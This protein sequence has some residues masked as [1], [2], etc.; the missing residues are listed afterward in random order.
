[1]VTT[2]S[3]A[4][5]TV[6]LQG[7]SDM[8]VDPDHHLRF[9]LNGIPVTETSFDGMKPHS[10]SVD[11][12]ASV[13]LEGAN[14]LSIESLTDTGATQS[15][16]YLDRFSLEYPHALASEAGSLEGQ[17]L[18]DGVV[19]ATGFAPGSV[20]IDLSGRVPRWMGRSRT[21]I[22]F[23]AEQGHSYLAVSPEAFLRPQIRP[24]EVSPLRDT[25]NQ[26]D[27]ILVAPRDFL[28][29][30]QPLVD[31]R[32]AQGLAVMAVALEDIYDSFG[33]GE[34]SPEAIHSF[35]S[36][37]YHHWTQPAP[38]YVLLLGEATS[39]PKG[40]LTG[41][42]RKDLLPTPLARSSFLWAPSDPLYASVNGD[43]LLPDFA[44]GRLNANSIAEAQAALQKI[45]DF[46]NGG[47]TLDGTA[48]LVA[49]NP[50]LAGDFEANLNDVASLLTARPTQKLFLTQLGAATRPAVL[51][52]FN[53]GPALVSY[54]GHGSQGN[55]AS[56]TIF[57]TND[58]PSLLPQDRPP[59]VLTMTCS[60]GYF[61]HPWSNGLAEDLAL[62]PQKG[63]IAAF[64]PTGLSLDAAAHVFHKALVTQLET[65]NHARIGDLVLAAQ[66]DY[67]Q[68]GAFPEL[69]AI[70]HLFGDPAL[71][72][73]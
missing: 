67:T 53:Q 18:T 19:Q 48:V 31:H 73:R 6:H 59:L 2:G 8:E 50:D 14:T 42:T 12:P 47:H 72:V 71:R 33:F 62:A 58:I 40:F 11:V 13:L 55:W 57:S 52:A 4:R 49:D 70:Y 15:F 41:P 28:P 26:A 17:A 63:A 43:D 44:I 66:A 9:S 46:E 38:R 30:A 25:T 24:V 3:P 29:T 65:G 68:S 20:L 16:V 60:N 61:T 27:W 39:D 1:V 54:V 64:S 35:L 36:F 7:G 37:A 45:L 69:L 32:Q 22:A 56:E 51:D 5:L 23:A 10:L 34:V 21:S